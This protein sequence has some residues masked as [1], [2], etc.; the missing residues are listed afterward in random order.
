MNNQVSHDPNLGNIND[1]GTMISSFVGDK[2]NSKNNSG[3]T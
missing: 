2:D 3:D 1:R